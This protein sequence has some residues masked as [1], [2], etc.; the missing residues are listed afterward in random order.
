MSLS[1]SVPNCKRLSKTGQLPFP[2]SSRAGPGPAEPLA[3]L[4]L[5]LILQRSLQPAPPVLA[6]PRDMA[7]EFLGTF[8]L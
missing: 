4:H 7:V 1:C 3:R 6:H 5:S 2:H 8:L